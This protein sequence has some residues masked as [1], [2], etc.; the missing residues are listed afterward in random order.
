MEKTPDQINREAKLVEKE[1]NGT[2]TPEETKEL[3]GLKKIK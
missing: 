1:N 3:E 2:I